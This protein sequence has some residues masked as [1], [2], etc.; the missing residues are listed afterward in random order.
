MYPFLQESK[1][2]FFLATQ[3]G[4]KNTSIEVPLYK[5]FWPMTLGQL[6]ASSCYCRF[7]SYREM[8]CIEEA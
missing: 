6:R 3:H 7:P 2:N 8:L 1:Q 5:Q 4:H